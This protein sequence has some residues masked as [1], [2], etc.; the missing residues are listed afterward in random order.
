[1]LRVNLPLEDVHSQV[2][3][4]VLFLCGVSVAVSET[5]LEVYQLVLETIDAL[6]V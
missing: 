1:M 5:V 3:L 4:F 2:Y 6:Q